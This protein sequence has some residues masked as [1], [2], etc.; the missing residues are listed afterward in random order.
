[1]LDPT[2]R[3]R[4][5]RPPV[6]RLSR[7]TTTEAPE[8]TPL[9]ETLDFRSRAVVELAQAGYT[10]AQ[11]SKLSRMPLETVETILA[12]ANKPRR[13][14]FGPLG[15]RKM[16]D[17]QI[18]ECLALH[19]EGWGKQRL[20]ARYGVSLASIYSLIKKSDGPATPATPGTVLGFPWVDGM[21]QPR[22]AGEA[23]TERSGP[24]ADRRADSPGNDAQKRG[25][26]LR[27]TGQAVRGLNDDG[28]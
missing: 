23:E 19:R 7:L 13:R 21:G 22:G 5:N 11:I 28:T 27:R 24:Q 17:E 26:V 2:E 8:P 4:G 12:E 16:S 25:L 15:T 10:P 6:T 14:L 20:A 1:M 3:L 18:S 9:W